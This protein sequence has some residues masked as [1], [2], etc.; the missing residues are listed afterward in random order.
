MDVD[1]PEQRFTYNH[2]DCRSNENAAFP[3]A[4]VKHLYSQG[5]AGI[6]GSLVAAVIM[7]ISLWHNVSHLYLVIWLICYGIACVTGEILARGIEKSS[8]LEHDAAYWSRLFSGLS[9]LG[10]VLWG[11]TPILLFPADSVSHQAL[12]TFVLGGMSVG[13]T[14]SHGAVRAA[15]LPFI[16]LVYIPLI[17]RYFY[18]GDEIH[19]S[20]GVLLL[21]FMIYLIGAAKRMQNTITESLNLRFQKEELIAVLTGEKAETDKLNESLRLEVDERREAERAL[22][23]SEA[24]FQQLLEVSPHPMIIHDSNTIFFANPSSARLYNASAPQLLV[25]KSIWDFVHPDSVTQARE[26]INRLTENREAVQVAELK[27]FASDRTT[28]D[29]EMVSISII[30]NG[31]PAILSIGRDIT[32]AKRAEEKLR[33]SLQEKEVLLREIHHRVKNNIQVLSSLLRLQSRCVGGKSLEEV[34][35]ESQN[36]LMSMALIHEKL[37]ESNDLANIDFKPYIDSLASHLFQ[38]FGV[39]NSRITLQNNTEEVL[40][41]LDAAIPCALLISE[42]I[43]NCLKHAFPDGKGGIIRLSLTSINGMTD[44]R[45][46]DNGIGMALPRDLNGFQTLGLRL[47]QA[48]IRQLKGE[49]DIQTSAGTSFHIR[50]PL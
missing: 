26:G 29:L 44:L 25:G 18:E 30:H 15:H 28:V 4:Q 31:T 21:V 3:A 19:M 47:V 50:F 5:L 37:Y 40:L 49:M 14:I 24:I 27:F 45:I 10:G 36:R 42:I 32:E 23:E 35:F 6:R 41:S 17:G 38:A 46:A 33:A 11:I 12:L 2:E 7:T 34:F 39:S 22:R 43:S 20:M 1:S 16:L 13:I 9:A 8:S 48:L